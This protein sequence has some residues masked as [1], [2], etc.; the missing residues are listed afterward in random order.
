MRMER[1]NLGEVLI[2]LIEKWR[3]NA[4]DL[5]QGNTYDQH[6]AEAIARCADELNKLVVLWES[7]Q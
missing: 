7:L 3:A 1:Q 6:D 5:L 2:E 4:K